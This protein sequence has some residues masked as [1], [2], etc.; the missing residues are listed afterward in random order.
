MN[1]P[2]H[3]RKGCSW[4]PCCRCS[5]PLRRNRQCRWRWHRCLEMHRR[6]R[7]HSP[8]LECHTIR[9]GSW[10]QDRSC[11]PPHPCNPRQHSSQTHS[12]CRPGLHTRHSCTHPR[13]CNPKQRH[14]FHCRWSLWRRSWGRTRW[15]NPRKKKIHMIRCPTRPLGR[16]CTL[17]QSYNLEPHSSRN[18]KIRR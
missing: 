5:L 1:R 7:F 13:W 15:C 9:L 18:R 2:P 14:S 4:T 16:S 6:H 8:L 17:P 10:P 11:R 12:C 3:W